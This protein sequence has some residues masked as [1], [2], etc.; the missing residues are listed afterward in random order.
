MGDFELVLV[1]HG[2]SCG[3]VARE[4]AEASGADRIALE[5][6][7][8]DTPLSELGHAQAAAVG[9]A[10]AD[11]EPGRRPG[12][13]WVSPYRRARDTA[14]PIAAA[15]GLDPVVDE[16]LRDRE[17]GVLDGVTSAGVRR[18]FADEAARRRWLG[19]L[20]YRPPGGESW[21]DVA[22]RIRAVLGEIDLSEPQPAVLVTH[23]AVILLVRYVLERL[24][25]A[26]LME[27]AGAGSVP[28]ASITRLV[29]SDDGRWRATQFGTVE[30]LEQRG[31]E[32][33]VHGGDHPH[34]H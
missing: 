3:N 29:R 22:L 34:G 5:W 4:E 6:R 8:P 21:A 20:Y 10:L 32:A 25:E 24:D 16:R 23:D 12:R 9:A 33:T 1:R 11:C 14:A 26:Q 7:D 2:E 17:L 15:C 28:N 13:L 18:L 31:V 19:K 30:H 27:L